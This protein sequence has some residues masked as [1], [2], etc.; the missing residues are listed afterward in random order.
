M[1]KGQKFRHK[2]SSTATFP[3]LRARAES[4]SWIKKTRAVM[5][6]EAPALIR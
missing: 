2:I 1:E 5:G 3:F 4:E 6:I